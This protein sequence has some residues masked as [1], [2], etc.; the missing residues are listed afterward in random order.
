[1]SVLN[2]TLHDGLGYQYMPIRPKKKPITHDEIKLIAFNKPFNVQSQ[3]S[4]DKPQQTLAHYIKTPHVYPAGRLD[5]DSE[6]L[7]LLTNFGTLQ[8]QIA[9]PR[10]KLEKTYWVLV[11][12]E[13]SA[14][15][16]SA[17]TTGVELKDGLTLPAKVRVIAEPE[18]L[19][20]RIPP[21][22]IRKSIKD[23]WLEIKITEGKNRQIRRMTAHV[24]LPTLR[25][26]RA[27]IGPFSLKSLQPGDHQVIAVS[28]IPSR[29]LRKGKN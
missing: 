29:L 19:W 13:P 12:G 18:N 22:R 5:K 14:A 24:G 4:G 7:L 8:A 26:I 1:M 3:F 23:S 9:E 15:Q 25:L 20:P 2:A 6:G 27:N 10:F 28:D 16:L 11:E 17:L 21:V